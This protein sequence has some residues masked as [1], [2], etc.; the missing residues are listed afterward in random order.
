VEDYNAQNIE[1]AQEEAGH[2]REMMVSK[3]WKI[4]CDYVAVKYDEAVKSLIIQESEESRLLIKVVAAIQLWP[5]KILQEV[6]QATKVLQEQ[7]EE[8]EPPAA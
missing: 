1:K 6:E 5:S 8:G 2:L 4:Y 7:E 3:G